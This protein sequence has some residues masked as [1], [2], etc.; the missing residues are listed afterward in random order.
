MLRVRQGGAGPAD[1]QRL[2]RPGG[3]A[4]RQYG[5]VHCRVEFEGEGLSELEKLP[6]SWDRQYDRLHLVRKVT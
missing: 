3:P 4:A 6:E 1:A 5:H 2:E